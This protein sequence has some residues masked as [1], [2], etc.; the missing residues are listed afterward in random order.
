MSR[1]I[2]PS[3]YACRV[4][5]SLILPS[6]VCLLAFSLIFPFP[7]CVSHGRFLPSSYLRVSGLHSHPHLPIPACFLAFS[8]IFPSL[9]LRVSGLPIHAFLPICV[10]LGLQPHPSLPTW[11]VSWPSASSFPPYMV[12]HLA[13]SHPSLLIC[14][15]RGFQPHSSL[16]I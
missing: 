11:F 2:L 8:F 10:S 13:F 9:Y 6:S 15:S 14:L 16:P 3:L 1:R 5:F 4:A 7:T 12:C